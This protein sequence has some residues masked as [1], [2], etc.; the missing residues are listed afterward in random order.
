[1]GIDSYRQTQ[2]QSTSAALA[3]AVE[4]AGLAPSMHNTQPLRGRVDGDTLEL[5]AEPPANCCRVMVAGE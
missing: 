5:H 1:M 2:A 4:A 3:D